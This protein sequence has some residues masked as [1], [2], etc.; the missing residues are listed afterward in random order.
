MLDIII[1]NGTVAD[2]SG[3]KAYR[4]DIGIKDGYIT[5]IK[6]DITD[7]AK[8]IIDASGKIVAPGFI[9]IHAHSDLCPFVPGL[10]PQSKLYQGVTL[11][12]IGNCGMSNLP[13]TDSSRLRLTEYITT[14]FDMP[15][16][17]VTLE[18]NSISDYAVHIKRF[19][20]CTNI[21][22]LIGHG[23]LRGCVAGFDMRPVTSDEQ[24]VM[25]KLLDTELTRGALGM[26]LGL[27]YPPSSYGTFDELAGLARVLSKHNAVLTVHMR[28]ESDK[29]FKAVDEVLEIAKAS[30]VRLQISHLKLIGKKQWEQADKLIQKIQKA[31]AEG[32]N[33]A[34]DQYPYTATST[35]LSAV[36]PKWA[37]DGGY[38]AMC[39]RLSNPEEKL[40]AEIRSEI[41]NRGGAEN[42]LITYTHGAI[43][44]VEGLTLAEISEQMELAPEQ[45]AAKL[46]VDAKG[47]V[48]CCY[49]SLS[50]DDVE[51]IMQED[52]VAV[53]SDGY[54]LT[55]DKNFLPFSP[56]PRSFGTFPRYFQT[57]RDKKLLPLEQ[58]VYKVTLL[59][60]N[61]LD[62]QDRGKIAEGYC[63][64]ITVFDYDNIRD[65]ST[66]MNA[67]QKPDGIE[68]VI[69]N[70]KIALLNG[71]QSGENMG[72]VV[73]HKQ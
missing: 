22:V 60:A 59:P 66:Y 61:I 31:R 24:R 37:M 9:D 1:K 23:T 29:I 30:K 68:A 65:N 32:I 42:I 67:L 21:G 64:D 35:G 2:G 38:G 49:F 71:E 36:V 44:Q 14:C 10:K 56:H 48:A 40:L 46:L 28:S 50:E 27:I 4:A 51:K 7:E 52:F 12:V 20:A 8:N 72:Q 45:A 58:A 17:G 3:R 19:P 18:D 57:I 41:D 39:L 55:F 43:P 63:A 62:L 53:G 54:A 11:E 16:H 6:P 25:E 26:S 15:L 34:S 33:V 47:G 69:I 13:V 5:A 73:L 70:G